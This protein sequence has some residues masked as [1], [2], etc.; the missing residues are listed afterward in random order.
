MKVDGPTPLVL[1]KSS[2]G[3]HVVTRNSYTSGLLRMRRT[4]QGR[5]AEGSKPCLDAHV[6]YSA[7]LWLDSR[8][9]R[10]AGG[11]PF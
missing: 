5:T 7:N 6:S 1:V 4:V 9:S 10:L 2:Y 8:G 3:L 11:M